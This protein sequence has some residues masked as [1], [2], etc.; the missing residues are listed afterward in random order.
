MI[1]NIPEPRKLISFI[2]HMMAEGGDGGLRTSKKVQ[3]IFDHFNTSKLR[4][5]IIMVH[6]GQPAERDALGF[7]LTSV[8]IKTDYS[9]V[10]S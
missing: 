1:L 7:V 10:L 8:I 6:I 4:T 2:L 3:P 5:L 9:G